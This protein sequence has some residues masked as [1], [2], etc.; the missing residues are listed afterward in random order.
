MFCISIVALTIL[1]FYLTLWRLDE[2]NFQLCE[3]VYVL[4]YG[5]KSEVSFRLL[6]CCGV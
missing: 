6:L 2:V 4:E 5:R 3:R 1:C